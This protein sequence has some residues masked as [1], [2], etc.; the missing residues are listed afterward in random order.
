M[1]VV[2][3]TSTRPEKVTYGSRYQ[4]QFNAMIG[5]ALAKC[6]GMTPPQPLPVRPIERRPDELPD[7]MAKAVRKA[8]GAK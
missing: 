8:G 5:R 3:L 4:K 6:G 7:W 2:A 1:S